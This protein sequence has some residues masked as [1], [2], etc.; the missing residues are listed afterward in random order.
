M[1]SKLSHLLAGIPT[2]W[3]ITIVVVGWVVLI[4]WLHYQM[5]GD[6]ETRPVLRMGYM[7]VITN[8]ACPVLDYVSRRGTGLR[9]EALKFASFAEM[10]EALR[11]GQIQAAFIIAP[12]AIVLHQQNTGVRIV[13]IGNR[14]ESTLV[15][16]K[17]L[18]VKTF[19]DLSGKTIAVPMRYSGHNI[20][21]RQ[22]AEKYGVSGTSL[23][24][25]EMN[26]PD[27]ASALVAGALDAYFV[28]EPFAAQTIRGGQAK[29]LH[30]VEEVWPGF[31]CNL[32]IVLQ[33]YIDAHPDRVQ[34]LVEGAARAGLWAKAHPMEAAAVAAQY[35]NQS[36]DLV[37]FTMST[38]QDRFVFDRFV[39]KKDEIQY[40][41][42]QM[43]KFELLKSNDVSG[44]VNDTFAK[45][46]DL[47]GITDTASIL[48]SPGSK[49][50][51]PPK[52]KD[53][54]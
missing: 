26:P 19:G 17:E 10:G 47:D 35:W 41:T 9:F 43:V 18:D 2:A 28:G 25:V 53:T 34:Q 48:H 24:I 20:A 32:V 51:P 7:P 13:Y 8:L 44:L 50:N 31:I 21:A 42:D 54:K 40:L 15:Y 11:N 23:K 16:R 39:P 6:R 27:M 29:V 33:S 30:F 12:L 52:H 4:S 36:I 46:A 3:R 38:P 1:R 22:L 5:N 49:K 45:A 14:H 37:R